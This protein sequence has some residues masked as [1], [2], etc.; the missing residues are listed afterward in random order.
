M[1]A[2]LCNV[3]FNAANLYQT[4]N[5]WRL[6]TPSKIPPSN[7]STVLRHRRHKMRYCCPIKRNPCNRLLVPLFTCANQLPTLELCGNSQTLDRSNS[8]SAISCSERAL[9]SQ[10]CSFF[11]ACESARSTGCIRQAIR[12]ALACSCMQRSDGE[13]PSPF[14]WELRSRRSR[15]SGG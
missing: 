6:T 14:G 2:G 9:P 4:E 12:R 7:H 1:R 13:Q 10:G 3:G 15:A 8:I 11:L 5:L